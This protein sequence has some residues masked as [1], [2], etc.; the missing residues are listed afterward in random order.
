MG[1]EERRAATQDARGSRKRC[2]LSFRAGMAALASRLS[3]SLLSSPKLGFANKAANP[4]T[5]KSRKYLS[6]GKHTFDR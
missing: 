2:I 3:Q 1:D 4:D 6:T 5:E